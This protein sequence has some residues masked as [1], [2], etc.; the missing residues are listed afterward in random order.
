MLQPLL[1]MIDKVHPTRLLKEEVNVQ[2][3]LT[4]ESRDPEL[5]LLRGQSIRSCFT[6]ESTAV[7]RGRPRA[8]PANKDSYGGANS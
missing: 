7:A 8:P 4:T 6:S 3:N 5:P 1:E 2:K